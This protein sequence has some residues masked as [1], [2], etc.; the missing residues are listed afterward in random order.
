MFPGVRKKAFGQVVKDQKEGQ[1]ALEKARGETPAR[2]NFHNAA[3]II[4]DNP[5]LLELRALQSLADS[6]GSTHVLGLP[7]NSI[8][9]PRTARSKPT[10]FAAPEQE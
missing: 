1:V 6:G 5:N 4:G 8:L 2:R 7:K 9:P 10:R 3:K